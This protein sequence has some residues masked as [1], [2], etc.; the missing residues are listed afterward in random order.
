MNNSIQTD[1]YLV[2][3]GYICFPPRPARLAVVVTSG[4]V[5]TMYDP[6][7]QRGG[8][9][10]YFRP[11]RENNM[12]TAIFAAP[13]ICALARMMTGIGSV[14]EDI[15]AH[16]YGGAE[17]PR[18]PGFIPDMA[19]RNVQI[20]EE[21]LQKLGIPLSRKEVG[22]TKPR[23]ILFHSQTGET[24]VARVNLVRT[25]DWYPDCPWS[26]GFHRGNFR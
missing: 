20:G 14:L 11:I 24:V 21:I 10:H 23:K 22:G 2:N 13:A 19:S 5:V 9:S 16:L 4:V 8:I 3:P 7:L 15:D 18:A 17:N 12:S 1:S 26:D 6:D 25:T